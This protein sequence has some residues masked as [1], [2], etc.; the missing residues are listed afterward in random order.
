MAMWALQRD[1]EY[2]LL[3]IQG[4][5][6]KLAD[7]LLSKQDSGLH[8]N[9]WY[10]VAVLGGISLGSLVLIVSRLRRMEVVA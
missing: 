7:W 6:F 4:N 1:S 3:S 10:S 8:W 5:F 9:P 2:L